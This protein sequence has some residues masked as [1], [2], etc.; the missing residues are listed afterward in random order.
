MT[1]RTLDTPDQLIDLLEDL[2]ERGIY[3]TIAFVD[4]QGITGVAYGIDEGDTTGHA[5]LTDPGEDRGRSGPHDEDDDQSYIGYFEQDPEAELTGPIDV[6]YHE[7]TPPGDEINTTPTALAA[8]FTEWHRR[9]TDEPDRFLAESE[10]LALD[11]GDYGTTASAYLAAILSG[12][13]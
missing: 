6:L 3:P 13:L 2:N 11:P 4:A 1:R 8:A 9:W 12:A 7:A 5:F 10:T